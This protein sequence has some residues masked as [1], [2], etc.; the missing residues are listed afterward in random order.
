MY[1][2]VLLFEVL[3]ETP[4]IKLLEE[5]NQRDCFKGCMKF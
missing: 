3:S 2:P 4:Q 5:L 1:H